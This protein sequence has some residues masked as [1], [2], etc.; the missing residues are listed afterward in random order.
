MIT[1]LPSIDNEL[2][3]RVQGG[4][5]AVE[6]CLAESTASS[7]PEIQRALR[8]LL[9]AGKRLRPL[10]VLSCG[11]LGD[12]NASGLVPAATC[13][14]LIHLASLY[15]DDVIDSAPFRRGVPSA[16]ARFGNRVA[17]LAGDY[18][19]AEAGRLAAI[20]GSEVV[21]LQSTTSRRLVSGEM[22]EMV[23][24]YTGP[25]PVG[26]YLEVAADKTASLIRCAAVLGG[27]MSG[28]RSLVPVLERFGEAL[29]VAFQIADDLLDLQPDGARYGKVPGA[30]LRNRVLNLPL[31]YARVETGSAGGRLGALLEADDWDDTTVAEA[32]QLLRRHPS[33]DRAVAD[34]ERLVGV[35]RACLDDLPDIPATAALRAVCDSLLSEASVVLR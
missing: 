8:H 18:L 6:R 28:A 20:L 35:C 22:R 29:G 24:S 13:C 21:D 34:A 25:D 9:P 5:A 16:N 17:V 27:L 31:I 15:H 26:N 32:L 19:F 10:L 3:L 7:V 12:P 1:D 4:L 30:D 11:Q 33:R 2:R 14:E 23:A